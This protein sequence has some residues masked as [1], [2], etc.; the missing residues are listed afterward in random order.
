MTDYRSGGYA[1][2][3]SLMQREGIA[4][5][6]FER[7]PAELDRRIDTLIVAYPPSG[8]DREAR[9]EPDLAALRLW[10]SAGGR[11]VS[12]GGEAAV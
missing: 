3:F 7:R 5:E 8:I 6:T 9:L 12:L 4:V 11:L 1:A 2:F 10:V